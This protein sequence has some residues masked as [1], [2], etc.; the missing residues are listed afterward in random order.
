MKIEHI[1]FA[2][3]EAKWQARWTK[4][5][6]SGPRSA[7]APGKKFYCLDMFPYP[8]ADGPARRPPR[9]LHRHRHP[10]PLPSACRASTSC[11]PWAGT[12]SACP[13]RTS[14]SQTGIHP[15]VVTENNIA[16][17]RRQIKSLGFS[18]DWDREIDTTDP[19]YY[20]WTQ[21]IF[22]QLF[23]KGL[24]YESTAPIN[25]CPS[26]KTG[27]A[28]EEVFDGA[29]E[30]CGTKVE[31]KDLRQWVLKITAYADRLAEDLDGLDWPE[32]TLAMQRNWI[33]RSEGARSPVQAR[34]TARD[35]L[36]FTTRPDTLFGATYMVLAPEHPLVA[37]ADD[38]RL[39]KTAVEAYVAQAAEQVGPGAHRAAEGEDRRLHRRLR[40][41][42]R[43]TGRGFRSGSPT[44]CWP[45]TAPA[46]SWPCRPT[47]SATAPSPTSTHLPIVEVV[48]PS[49]GARRPE[50]GAAFTEDGIAVNSPLFEGLP[51]AEAKKKIIAWLEQKKLGHASGQIQAARLDL[52]PPALLGRADPPHPLPQMRPRPRP[53]GASC[54]CGCPR[55]PTTSPPAPA[56]RRWPP[57]RTG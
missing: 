37:E 14:P 19:G 43:S 27:L 48:Q 29:C 18:Y 30:R 20:K 50:E 57:S 17:F 7:R 10:L 45:A 8:S 26:C 38:A 16:N 11:T 52:L 46:P 34:K 44:T 32:S 23:K 49:Q 5:E 54:P 53:R 9:R 13:P 12:P 6:S 36:I 25:W 2:E 47:T 1:P 40:R 33:G 4:E 42:T 41:S 22:L 56:N 31:R 51:T 21:W 3:I 35:L 55:S 39:S 15:R 28:N 24:A